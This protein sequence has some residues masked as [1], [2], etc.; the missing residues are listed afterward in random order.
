MLSLRTVSPTRD[1]N[2]QH[3]SLFAILEPWLFY[4]TLTLIA[5]LLTSL[6]SFAET[7]M[8]SLSLLLQQYNLN[9]P[10]VFLGTI[11]LYFN[12]FPCTFSLHLSRVTISGS[13]H[14]SRYLTNPSIWLLV[15]FSA[16]GRESW[17]TESKPGP[18]LAHSVPL[19]QQHLLF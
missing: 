1:L 19:L 17:A 12:N 5:S 16:E 13:G 7:I 15:R 11:S 6:S 4:L 8:L 10:A 18:S 3:F 2:L 9:S 14:P